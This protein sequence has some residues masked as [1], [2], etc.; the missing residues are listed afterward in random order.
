MGRVWDMVLTPAKQTVLLAYADH[1]DHD[2]RNIHPG[3][4][5]IAW[6]T[7]YSERQVRRITKDLEADGV[8]VPDFTP[9]GKPT[10]YHIDYEKGILKP[11]F[12]R[13][14]RRETPDKMTRVEGGHAVTP[15][16]LSPV[17]S[18]EEDET[19]TPDMPSAKTVRIRH[20]EEP[21][22]KDQESHARD[23]TPV[24]FHMAHGLGLVDDPPNSAKVAQ[25]K[26]H[27][28]FQA[29][30]RGWDGIEP[31]VPHQT[32]DTALAALAHLQAG[33]DA[34]TYTLDD[35]EGVTRQR[36]SMPRAKPYLL[37]YV[38]ADLPG[39]LA[40]KRAA[41]AGRARPG[42]TP[43]PPLSDALLATQDIDLNSLALE[44]DNYA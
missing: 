30:A 10:V 16:M 21:S 44:E 39:Y 43:A 32:A 4:P 14:K 24:P 23:S 38:N 12:E 25:V 20:K 26:A 42:D 41:S 31:V 33:I 1:A 37:I 19:Q 8:L 36:L 3:V 34:G 18:H 17:T 6:K 2:G 5:L 13:R 28:V 29:F 22:L 35:I 7:G 9:R 15:D 11:P 40:S 27:P